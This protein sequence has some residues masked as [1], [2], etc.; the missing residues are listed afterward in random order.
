MLLRLMLSTPA[1]QTTGELVALQEHVP[2]IPTG[3][4]FRAD[5]H[6]HQQQRAFLLM[7]QPSSGRKLLRLPRRRTKSC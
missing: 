4:A 5:I 1:A 3:D 6:A 7:I 2:Q